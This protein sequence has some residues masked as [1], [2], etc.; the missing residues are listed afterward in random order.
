MTWLT[1]GTAKLAALIT[2]GWGGALP[3]TGADTISVG[4]NSLGAVVGASSSDR[5]AFNLPG[6]AVAVADL[7][8]PSAAWN[9]RVFVLHAGH[10]IDVTSSGTSGASMLEMLQELLAAGYRVYGLSMPCNAPQAS[11]CAFTIGSHSYSLAS[12]SAFQTAAE[13]GPRTIRYFVDPAIRCAVDAKARYGS[14]TPVYMTGISGGGWTTDWAAALSELFA[15]SY[16][17]EGSLPYQLRFNG[18]GTP[19]GDWEQWYSAPWFSAVGLTCEELYVLGATSGRRRLVC[20]GK[21]DPVFPTVNILPYVEAIRL[22][23]RLLCGAGFDIFTDD[24]ATTHE[25]TAAIRAEIIADAGAL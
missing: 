21:N 4:S 19:T 25:Y 24:A 13:E 17:V 7:F 16:P 11:S 12:H 10:A 9:G 23:G 22:T 15:A 2:L 6:G 20:Y 1:T 18:A 8:H 5:L 14:S 3:T